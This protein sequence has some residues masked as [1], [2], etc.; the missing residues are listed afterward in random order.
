LLLLAAC[1]QRITEGKFKV[2]G[3]IE[4]AK[5]QDIYLDQLFFSQQ[6]P[7]ALD[8]ARIRNGKFTLSALATEEGLYRLRLSE[9]GA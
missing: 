6:S 2:S 9:G 7:E 8:T 5:D 3:V 4:H 1:S